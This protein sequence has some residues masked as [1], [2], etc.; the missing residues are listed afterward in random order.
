VEPLPD[1]DSQERF[2]DGQPLWLGSTAR[3]GIA[4]AR[5]EG[6]KEKEGERQPRWLGSIA[7]RD[8]SRVAG[9]GW[10]ETNGDQR[11]RWLGS[12]A[13]RNLTAPLGATDS[14]VSPGDDTRGDLGETAS[15]PPVDELAARRQARFV[16][17][18][19]GMQ[20]RVA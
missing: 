8:P 13:R 4:G 7:R 16:T 12:V 11:P 14:T 2:R 1:I 20:L 15:P 18:A 10:K 17:G 5:G 19:L 6:W 3:R 9:P